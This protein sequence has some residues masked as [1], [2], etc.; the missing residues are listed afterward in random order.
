[1]NIFTPN[2]ASF[3]LFGCQKLEN[4]HNLTFLVGCSFKIKNKMLSRALERNQFAGSAKET[5]VALAEF[6]L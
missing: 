3:V 4:C 1:L 5:A 2:G 6:S